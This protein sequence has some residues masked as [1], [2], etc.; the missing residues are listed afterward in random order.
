MSEASLFLNCPIQRACQFPFYLSHFELGFQNQE[1][2][3]SK[4]SLCTMKGM[5]GEQIAVLSEGVGG[6]V[7]AWTSE[8]S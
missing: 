2:P 4:L 6:K 1:T 3:V 5:G 8:A 7:S